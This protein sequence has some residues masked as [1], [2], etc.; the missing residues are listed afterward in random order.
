M[1]AVLRRLGASRHLFLGSKLGAIA[2]ALCLLS[3]CG[4]L[5]NADPVPTKSPG[6]SGSLEPFYGQQVTWKACNGGFECARIRVPLS[7][8]SPGGS[9]IELAAARLPVANRA[10]KIGALLVNPGGPGGSAVGYARGAVAFFSQQVVAAYDIVGVDPRGVGESTPIECLD[11][12]QSDR[13]ISSLGTPHDPAQSVA[14]TEVAKSVGSTCLQ[15][16]PDLT[17]YVG[18]VA[19]ARDMDIVRAVLIEPKLNYFG[20][21]YGTFLGLTYADLFPTKV[22]RFVLDGVIDP[23][24]TNDQLAKGQAEGFQLALSAFIAD[25][26]KHADC[27]LPS[28]A[29]KGLARIQKFL[30]SLVGNPLPTATD[31]PLTQPMAVTSIIG[32]LYEPADGWPALRFAL[33]SAFSGK[34]SAMLMIVDSFT[35]RGSGGAYDDNTLDAL[36][37]VNCLDRPDRAD[38]QQTRQLGVEWAKTAPTFGSELAYSNL[39]CY[40]WPAP[41]TD[42]PHPIR[43][44]GA[45]P[46]VLIGTTRDPATPYPWAVS[47]ASQLA[48]SSLITWNGDG[49]TGHGRGVKCVDGPVDSYL[50]KGV[51][52]PATVAC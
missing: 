23:T 4:I 29:A 50:V 20:K 12:A 35:G 41:A 14:V 1:T 26:P 10:K 40:Q 28:G 18:T 51:V 13:L 42:V 11:A 17:P 15:N 45:E 24:L 37:A 33:Q 38:P 30:A 3:A 5:G 27:P 43:A 48:E 25:C 16:S 8:E 36:Y 46:I 19:A 9:V 21:S 34:G 2:I 22:G 6:S 49:H 39:P 52:P 32:S 47:V 44:E 31:R 7:Y